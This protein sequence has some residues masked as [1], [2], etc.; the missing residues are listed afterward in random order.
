M[1]Y[2][3]ATAGIAG[4]FCSANLL[5]TFLLIRRVNA[6][7][8]RL[9]RR[10][11]GSAGLVALSAGEPAPMLTVPTISGGT[12]SLGGTEG[13]RSLIAFL[14]PGCDACH[15]Q[16]PELR[17]YARTIPGGAARVL[18]V[19]RAHDQSVAVKFAR[20][21]TGWAS[22]ALE[23]PHGA[24]QKAFSVSSYPTFYTIAGNGKVE[25]GGLAVRHLAGARPNGRS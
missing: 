3:A 6:H 17:E 24:A 2:L 11:F 13:D 1:A 15:Q 14:A 7:A 5:L 18:A 8:E 16:L 23:S 12:Y 21:L 9:P 4:L 25:A 10:R 19:V 20:E 22:V